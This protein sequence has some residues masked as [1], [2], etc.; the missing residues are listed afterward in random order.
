MRVCVLGWLAA[1]GLTVVVTPAETAATATDPKFVAPNLDVVPKGTRVDVL[2]DKLTYD[3]KSN[4]ATA[5]GTVR[6]TY[7]PYVLTATRVTYDMKRGVFSA[8][9][10]I[11]LREPNGNVLEAEVAEINDK[12]A[13]GFAEHVRA[14]LT[15]NV[16]ITARYA[17]RIENGITIY[18]QASYTACNAC[19]GEN[20]VPLWRI[21]AGEATHDM[22]EHT[23]H[24]KDA[25]LEIGGVPVLWAPAFS[26][27]DPSVKRRSGFLLPSFRSG[28][29]GIGMTA[30][31]FWALAPDKDLTLLPTFTTQQGPLMEA[32]WRHRL[33]GGIYK[34]KAA[35]IYEL[36]P[37]DTPRDNGPGRG[38]LRGTGDFKL[39][40]TWK[41]G[42]DGTIWSDRTFLKDYDIDDRSMVANEVHLTG[43]ADRSFAQAQLLHYRTTEDTENQGQMPTALPFVTANY[44]FADPMT[45]GE[46]S[47][48]FNAYSVH[49][50]GTVNDPAQGTVLGTD[51]SHV[52]GALGWRRQ[53]TS[54]AGILVTPFAQ[55][56]GDAITAED[57]PGATGSGDPQGYLLPSAGFDLRWPFIG[58]QGDA[59]G[60]LTPV[61]QLI[62][63]PDEPRP[64]D[65]ANED[66]ITL[67]FDTTNLF[68]SDRFSGFDRIEGGVRANAGLSYTWL[69]SD[70][71]F[72][73][74]SFGESFHIAGNNSFVEGSGLDGTASDLVG[75]IALQ[76]NEHVTLGYQARVEED[77]S[78]LNVQEASLGL[79]LDRISGSLSYA[80][81]AAAANYGRPDREQQIWG[82]AKYVLSEAWGLFGGFRYDI[83]GNHFMSKSIGVGFTC[84]CMNAH[85]TYSQSYEKLGTT[86]HRFELG[87]ELRTIG[88]FDGG[89]SL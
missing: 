12:F 68:L 79:T 53:L 76:L 39:N 65:V 81:I 67:N 89:F 8:N 61:F 55:L 41:W 23:I 29:Y 85:F 33:A 49:R 69:A 78:R 74:T 13:K 27:P 48:D 80:G 7:G 6:L 63:A 62:A 43:L 40:D 3:G 60:V 15:N 73:R 31:Y 25:S 2:A 19:A 24:Y 46:L 28:D 77:L 37:S 66:A 32:E 4:V 72:V 14:L 84:D 58:G 71:G 82:D 11:V 18:E 54:N 86:D 21:V 45:G 70:G 10:S 59:Q 9:G 17:R 83:E 5:T 16:T 38:A 42:W 22:K 20:G 57:V 50:D 30:P 56:R 87:V 36:E 1:V 26:Y 64:A 75:A 51:Q 47:F 35:G 44:I 34:L 88:K 52:T